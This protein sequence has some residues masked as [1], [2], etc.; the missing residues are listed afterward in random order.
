MTAFQ[1]SKAWLPKKGA[2]ELDA[3]M[4]RLK[5]VISERNVSEFV[6]SDGQRIDHLEIPAYFIA[7]WIAENWWPLLWEPRKS[8]EGVDNPEFIARHS[9]LAAQHGFALP[10]VNFIPTGRTIHIAAHA[11]D[12][13]FAD[14]RFRNNSQAAPFREDVEKELATFVSAVCARLE[15]WRILDTGL[16]QAWQMV[17]DVATDELQFCQF[18]GA[19]GLAP[20]DVGDHTA[21]LLDRLLGKLGP[22]LLMDLCLVAL[23]ASFDAIG[24]AAETAFDGLNNVPPA[25]LE[26]LLALP[27][28]T[29]SFSVPA[30]R[31]GVQAAKQLRKRLG[32]EET[33]AD[34]ATRIFDR[35]R[36]DT[37]RYGSHF[38]DEVS[39][40]GAVSRSG[41]EAH[42]AQLN[43]AVTQRRFAAARAVFSAWT[44]DVN[45]KRFLTSAVTRDQQASRAFAAELTAP[46]ALLRARSKLSKLSQD[47]VFDLASEL[48]IG[49]DVVSKQAL[50][51]GLTV[52]PA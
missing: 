22:R 9:L 5:L 40:T 48:Q 46:Y 18:A 52:K 28:P 24:G 7:E 37:G 15:Q 16:Q 43:P 30:W 2:S 6:G 49:T 21:A 1:I 39:L 11:R 47:Q 8:E 29:D 10:R 34:G 32:I 42:V 33:N 51:N 45:E 31:R 20:H 38:A 44:A 17:Q 23:P 25:T 35:L 14:V 50:N 27:V 36:L 12:V 4:A 3:T 41:G 19:L 26:P 13:T